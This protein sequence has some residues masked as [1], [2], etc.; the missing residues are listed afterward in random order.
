MKQLLLNSYRDAFVE[1]RDVKGTGKG[2]ARVGLFARVK[3]PPFTNLGDYAGRL[4]NLDHSQGEA[5]SDYAFR[6]A[7]SWH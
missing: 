6:F 5:L 4:V 1:V 7:P 3:L 2:K